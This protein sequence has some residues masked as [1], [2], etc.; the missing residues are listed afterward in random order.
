MSNSIGPKV[1]I[2]GEAQFKKAIADINTSLRTMGTE[3][4]A[5]TSAYDR[6]DKSSANLTAQNQVLNKQIDAQRQKVSDLKEMVDKST[7]AYG[8]NDARTQKYQQQLNSATAALNKSELQL[9]SNN[10][11]LGEYANEAKKATWQTQEFKDKTEKMGQSLKDI[12]G[13]LAGLGKTMSVAV[14]APLMAAGVASFKFVADLEDAM[15]ASDQIFKS[16]SNNMKKWAD[17]LSSEYGIAEAEAL[18]YANTMGAMLQ[19]IGCLSEAEASKQSQTLVQLA[20]DLAAMFGGTTESAV[21]ALTGALKGNNAMLDNY[22]M[23]VNDATIKAKALEMGIYSGTGAMELQTKQAATLALIMEQ[24]ADAQGQAGREADGASGSMRSMQTELKN[25]STDIGEVLLPV[26]TPLIASLRDMVKRFGE[27]SPET[28]KTIVV[29][30]GLAA[31][32]GPLLIVIGGA[33]SAVGTITAALPVLGAALAALTGPVGLVVAAIAGAVAIGVALYKNWD[34]IKEKAGALKDSVVEKFE[35]VKEGITSKINASRDAVKAAIDKIKGFFDFKWELPKLKLPH[36]DIKGK[37]SLAPPS[38]PALDVDWYKTGAI[39]N[40]PSVI[41]VGES[42]SEAVIPIEKLSGILSETMRSIPSN[43]QQV[44]I[45][46]MLDGK[47]LAR[48]LYNP[49]QNEGRVRGRVLAGG[50]V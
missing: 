46:V 41:G 3:M 30:A 15:G 35:A 1:G 22:G 5:V 14:T 39:F 25:L 2:T 18:S 44:N 27:L 49:L 34:T 24:T 42:G 38:V 50:T 23:G 6:N 21:Q 10:K 4:K 28:Q 16:A 32:I 47:V 12:G 20:G 19:N 36:F 13:K 37:F 26:I 31:A 11:A 7:Q 45:T 40:K 8:E 17:A 48:Q 9:R 33:I 29:V 43:N